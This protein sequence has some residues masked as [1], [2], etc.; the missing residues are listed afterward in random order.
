MLTCIIN[1]FLNM[2]KGLV[3][4]LVF[5]LYFNIQSI[6]QQFKFYLAFED[7]TTAK[8]TVWFIWDNTCTYNVD[9]TFGE[10]FVSITQD[11][12]QVYFIQ[13]NYDTTKVFSAPSQSTTF[14]SLLFIQHSKPPIK[15]KWDTALLHNHTL[16]FQISSSFFSNGYIGYYWSTYI[17]F[18]NNDSIVFPMPYFDYLTEGWWHKNTIAFSKYPY[19]IENQYIKIFENLEIT[20]E[21]NIIEVRDKQNVVTKI[22]VE[23]AVTKH[24]I[25]LNKTDNYF[26]SQKL[27]QGEYLLKLN[28]NGEIIEI[29]INI[30]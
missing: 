14:S 17:S 8:D 6:A 30:K 4:F 19:Y 13:P 21:N 26:K 18:F 27:Q 10:S 11:T 1:N 3:F 5:I 12:F 24:R 28:A 9:N 7:S 23:Q 25:K 2:K 15:I 29:P 20:T 22:Y 16:P